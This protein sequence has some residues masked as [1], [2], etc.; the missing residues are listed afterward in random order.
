[1]QM[2]FEFILKSLTGVSDDKKQELDLPVTVSPSPLLTLIGILEGGT[3][4]KWGVC[5]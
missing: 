4:R 1:M 3:G 2:A 5:A